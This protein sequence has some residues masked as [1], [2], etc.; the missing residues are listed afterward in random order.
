MANDKCPACGGYDIV[1]GESMRNLTRHNDNTYH[2]ECLIDSLGGGLPMYIS[3]YK[4][5]SNSY[6]CKKYGD[7]YEI[8]AEGGSSAIKKLVVELNEKQG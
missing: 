8:E 4:A 6:L 2:T 1:F 7:H 5:G 3:V